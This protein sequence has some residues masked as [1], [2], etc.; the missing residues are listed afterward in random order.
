MWPNLAIPLNG[1]LIQLLLEMFLRPLCLKDLVEYDL[2][3]YYRD[4]DDI[5]LFPAGIAERH[6]PGGVVGPTFACIIARQFRAL[7]VSD[8]F[9]HERPDPTVR[10]TPGKYR[11]VLL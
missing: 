8:R 4:V 7:R 5:D 6:V 3:L 10:F 2:W 1:F 9:W 11:N